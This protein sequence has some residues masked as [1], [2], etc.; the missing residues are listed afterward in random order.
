MR[1]RSLAFRLL[2]PLVGWCAVAAAALQAASPL[3]ALLVVAFLLAGPGAA[4]VRVCAPALRR[5]RASEHDDGFARDS[6]LLEQLVLTLFLSLSAA[7]VCATA[8]LAT[9]AFSGLRV[10]MLLAAATTLAACCPRLTGRAAA[11]RAEAEPSSPPEK[12]TV[13]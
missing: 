8:L 1:P 12:G 2:P 4:V 9:G 13:T 6:D 5:Y 10:L 11:A 3:R 7:V